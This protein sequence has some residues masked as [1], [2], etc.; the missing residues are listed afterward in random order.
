MKDDKDGNRIEDGGG[1][2]S[3]TVDSL[4]DHI[5]RSDQSSHRIEIHPIERLFELLLLY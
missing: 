5:G 3:E 4:R 1:R 2:R